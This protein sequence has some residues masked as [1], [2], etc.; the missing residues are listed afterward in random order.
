MNASSRPLKT[1]RSAEFTI[2]HRESGPARAAEPDDLQAT[3]GIVEVVEVPTK[4]DNDAVFA[5]AA[6]RPI[7][8]H[9]PAA[10]HS[11]TVL[12]HPTHAGEAG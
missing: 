11:V 1:N 2:H 8:Q 12:C 5:P 6:A 4:R 7:H 9:E 3:T 10:C